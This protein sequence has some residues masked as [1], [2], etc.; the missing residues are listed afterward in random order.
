[1][2]VGIAKARVEG[3]IQREKAD[4]PRKGPQGNSVLRASP[5][6]SQGRVWLAAD[7]HGR[8]IIGDERHWRLNVRAAMRVDHKAPKLVV[9]PSF[10]TP[11][12]GPTLQGEYHQLE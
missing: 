10:P 2:L 4:S 9:A 8:K 11:T 3:K 5:D 12:P 6:G 1:M 7:K